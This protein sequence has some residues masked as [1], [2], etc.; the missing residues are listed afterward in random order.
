M[1]SVRVYRIA[2][3]IA[4]LSKQRTRTRERE[5]ERGREREGENEYERERAE[6]QDGIEKKAGIVQLKCFSSIALSHTTTML[7]TYGKQR[8]LLP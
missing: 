6:D 3:V 4:R 7:R 5:R 8:T 2:I 1:L